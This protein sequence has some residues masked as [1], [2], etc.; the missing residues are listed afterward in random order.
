[1]LNEFEEKVNDMSLYGAFIESAFNE[2]V[3]E[4]L[5]SNTIVISYD[6]Y[7]YYDEIVYPIFK[8]LARDF[9]SEEKAREELYDVLNNKLR[10][11]FDDANYNPKESG[12]TI[13][14][15][16]NNRSSLGFALD[17]DE[18][19]ELTIK[20]IKKIAGYKKVQ[21]VIEGLNKKS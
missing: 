17:I 21:A 8:R 16:V 12:K 6:I 14:F 19:V 9:M 2:S 5:D 1:M 13:L 10:D 15:A 3:L 4:M 18:F 7:D 20:I 11:V